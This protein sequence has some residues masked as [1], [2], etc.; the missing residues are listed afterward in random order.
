MTDNDAQDVR[1]FEL[2]ETPDG[3]WVDHNGQVVTDLGA[4]ITENGIEALAITH[5]PGEAWS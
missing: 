5:E 2:H 1:V 4:W 3:A